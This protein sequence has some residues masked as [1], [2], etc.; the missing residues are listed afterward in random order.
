MLFS[1]PD[2]PIKLSLLLG[3]RVPHL[4]HGSLGLPESVAQMASRSVQPFSQG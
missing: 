3:D 2:N 4:I 1:G